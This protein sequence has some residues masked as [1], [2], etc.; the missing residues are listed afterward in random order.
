[1]RT[2]KDLTPNPSPQKRG[3][4][5]PGA[6]PRLRSGTPPALGRGEPESHASPRSRGAP[7]SFLGKG[8]GGLGL[9]LPILIGLA[10]F[11]LCLNAR[12]VLYP[13]PGDFLWALR[14]A[15]DLLAGHDPYAYPFSPDAVPYPLPAA[16]IGLPFAGLPDDWAAASFFGISSGLLAYA[17]ARRGAWRLV[18]FCSPAYLM[19]LW[20]AQ[21]TPLLMAMAFYPGLLALLL[22]KP[23]GGLPLAL[24]TGRTRAGYV[25]AGVTLA[26]SLIIMPAWPLRWLAQLRAYE[27]I[28]PLLV[29]PGPLILLALLA[30]RQPAAR[31]LLLMA[32]VPQR[33]F[34]DQF[35]LWLIPDTLRELLFLNFAAW[36]GWGLRT[37]LHADWRPWVIVGFYFPAL[38]L[39]LY[40]RVARRDTV[41]Q[42][43]TLC[44]AS[45]DI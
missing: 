44:A 29:L 22:V 13:G 18:A 6:A 36:L 38:A 24:T 15:R 8:V 20:F 21:W 7:P 1:M 42:R 17:L 31:L 5:E 11:A 9:L 30:W 4:P 25:V 40:R 23:Q 34:Y 32:A 43:E 3:E 19:A 27:G 14:S 28:V 2:R 12:R 35:V 37:Y 33:M 10:S 39:V 41:G 16:L 26:A 45:A